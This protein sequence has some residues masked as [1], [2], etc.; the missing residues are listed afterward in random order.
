M[1]YTSS[2]TPP[3]AVRSATS[4]TP[5]TS[6]SSRPEP[7][8]PAP[9]ART[10]VSRTFSVLWQDLRAR[11][12]TTRQRTPPPSAVQGLGHALH[13]LGQNGKGHTQEELA[14][15]LL[16]LSRRGTPFEDPALRTELIR[17]LIIGECHPRFVRAALSVMLI[18]PP[19]SGEKGLRYRAEFIRVLLVGDRSDPSW[20]PVPAE[21]LTA[22]TASLAV[23]LMTHLE[24]LQPPL[25][26][27]HFRTP[28]YYAPA[29]T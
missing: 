16:H 5:S 21:R 28:D 1:S 19:G 11:I 2:P 17:R 10:S 27:R 9:A 12:A 13:A 24:E 26:A 15:E 20:S 6:V 3:G 22:L 7:N 25:E 14:R 4:S 8:R 29:A 18:V 23:E